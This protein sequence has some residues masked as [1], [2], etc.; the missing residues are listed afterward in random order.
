MILYDLEE[1]FRFCFCFCFAILW[2]GAAL[3]LSYG[4][5]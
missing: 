2:A 1:E 5:T 3:V 4:D